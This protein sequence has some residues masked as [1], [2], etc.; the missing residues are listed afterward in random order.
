MVAREHEREPLERQRV[1]A[2]PGLE[3]RTERDAGIHDH[4]EDSDNAAEDGKWYANR[5]VGDEHAAARCLAGERRGTLR[6]EHILLHDK[7]E[8]RDAQQ[9]DCHGRGTLLIVGSRDLQVDGRC[10]RVI[11][12]ADDHGVR[13]VS[14]GFDEGDKEGIAEAWKDERQ[15]DA[16]EDLP[17]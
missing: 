4:D 9:H 17:P 6:F 12:S 16:R 11:R 15:R 1:V 5:V 13:E 8:K 10:Q 14:D 3:E 2:A 7:H